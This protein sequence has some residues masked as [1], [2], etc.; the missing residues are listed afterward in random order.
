MCAVEMGSLELQRINTRVQGKEKKWSHQKPS[1][2]LNVCISWM[3][4]TKFKSEYIEVKYISA[5]S[6]HTIGPSEHGTTSIC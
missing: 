1:R 3:Y 2:K 6:K 4:V 5:H